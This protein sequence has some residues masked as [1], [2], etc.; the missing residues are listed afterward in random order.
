MDAQRELARAARTIAKNYD[1]LR[2]AREERRRQE[3]ARK[4]SFW[5]IN[6]A[7]IDT[8]RHLE[9]LSAACEASPDLEPA[10]REVFA[11]ADAF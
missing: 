6:T 5:S 4:R 9:E 3:E 1:E 7:F 10:C 11:S 8:K 2:D